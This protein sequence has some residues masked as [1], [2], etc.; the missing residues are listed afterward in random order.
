[1]RLPTLPL[2][3]AILALISFNVTALDLPAIFGPGMVLQRDRAVPVWGTTEAG[4]SVRVELDGRVI[5][6]GAADAKGAF[7][8]SLPSRGAGGPHVVAV[9]SGREERRLHDVYFGDVWLCSG[10]SN[11]EWPLSRAANPDEEVMAANDPRIR[12]FLVRKNPSAVPLTN[13]DGSWTPCTPATAAPFSAVAYHFARALA[14][15]TNVP[16]GLIGSYWGGSTVEAW[17]PPD[18][19]AGEE[20]GP[21]LGRRNDVIP[22]RDPEERAA[23]NRKAAAEQKR[24][25]AGILSRP[26]D[27]PVHAREAGAALGA[28]WK[29]VDVPGSWEGTLGEHFDGVVWFRR[30]FDVPPGREKEAWT[31]RLGVVD[32]YDTTWLNGKKIGETGVDAVEPWLTKRAY[33]VP[34]GVLRPGRNVLL[35]RAVDHGGDGGFL[36]EPED[37]ELTTDGGAAIGLTGKWDCR[38]EEKIRFPKFTLDK[39]ITQYTA[40]LLFDGMIAP[41]VPYGLSGVIW[42]QGESNTERAAQYARLFP[43][44]IRSWRERWGQGDFPFYFVQLANHLDRAEKPG[45]SRWAELRESQ[46]KTLALPNTG[47]ALT[48]DIGDGADIHPRN[49]RD[50]G[51]RLASL[52][53]A[54]ADG[55]RRQ[56][57]GPTFREVKWDGP[58]GRVFFDQVDGGLVTPNNEPVVGFAIA[59]EDRRFVWAEA[60][61]E[62]DSVVV[63]SAKVPRPVAI[64]YAWANNPAVNLATKEGLPV[65]PFRTDSWPL[66]TAGKR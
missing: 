26:V 47:M 15:K 52:A 17:I 62:G 32:D 60:R 56:V 59:G 41:L 4:A 48:I 46:T 2:A 19:L 6:E 16:I 9:K 40:G 54:P 36:G 53:L 29:R 14:E 11:M 64:R 57:S 27:L 23:G 30:E 61:I 10:Q 28:E 34:A 37:L 12:F 8:L 20:F 51:R 50:V 42:Y 39:M 21:V 13:V 18:A 7:R 3:A 1:M 45:P 35:V 24:I 5:A 58:R 38:V 33:P 25:V 44:L 22:P 55:K 49:K 66:T 65:A 31:L 43:T 63:S